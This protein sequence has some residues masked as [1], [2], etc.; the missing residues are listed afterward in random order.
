MPGISVNLLDLDGFTEI[1]LD[2][3]SFS[4][5][6]EEKICRGL[7]VF[8][9][10]PPVVQRCEVTAILVPFALKDRKLRVLGCVAPARRGNVLKPKGAR[11]IFVPLCNDFYLRPRR[12]TQ[13][14]G[15]HAGH[16]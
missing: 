6:V 5:S 12:Q 1:D 11:A 10:K 16:H 2:S 13:K 8:G 4:P 3:S 7:V 9:R 15:G 14:E